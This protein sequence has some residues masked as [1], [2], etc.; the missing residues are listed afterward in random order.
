MRA[1]GFSYNL[2]ISWQRL[3]AEVMFGSRNNDSFHGFATPLMG[4]YWY[5]SDRMQHAHGVTRKQLELSATLQKEYCDLCSTLI[6]YHPGVL[7]WCRLC[8]L[9]QLQISPKLRNP[10]GRPYIYWEKKIN[11]LNYLIQFGAAV[12]DAWCTTIN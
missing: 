1:R 9:N 2:I 3:L 6:V 11:Q 7:I 4:F 8:A 12:H 10:Y 5:L